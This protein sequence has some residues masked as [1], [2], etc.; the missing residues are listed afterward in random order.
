MLFEIETPRL[1]YFKQNFDTE[2]VILQQ[3]RE[4]VL[5]F[6]ISI[7]PNKTER[8]PLQMNEV[9]RCVTSFLCKKTK[10]VEKA[11]PCCTV[12]THFEK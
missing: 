4:Q 1:F 11:V 7:L 2:Q 9:G 8:F 5:Y 12:T 10:T 3:P 6:V